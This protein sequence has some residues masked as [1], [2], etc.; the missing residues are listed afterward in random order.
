VTETVAATAA[1]Q[2]QPQSRHVRNDYVRVMS[3]ANPA[4]ELAARG[5]S[6]HGQHVMAQA[7]ATL[8]STAS[9]LSAA[10]S[11]I[12]LDP[13]KYVECGAAANFTTQRLQ[14]PCLAL[15]G[16]CLSG[17]SGARLPPM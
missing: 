8:A 9:S 1:E 14:N 11:G 6:T 2:R 4:V 12:T 15:H 16:H 17:T 5:S 10:P 13:A 7:T 3:W